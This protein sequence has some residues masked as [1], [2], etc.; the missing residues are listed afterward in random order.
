MCRCKSP[1]PPFEK[2]GNS[3]RFEKG[4]NSI[5]FPNSDLG[6]KLSFS[7][8]PNSDLGRNLS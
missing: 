8:F 1:L 4:E 3:A 6:R 7:S 2:G 5:S